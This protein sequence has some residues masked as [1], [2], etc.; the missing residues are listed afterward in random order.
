MLP[1]PRL[2]PSQTDKMLL[3]LFYFGAHDD[4]ILAFN[5]LL[6]HPYL[7]LISETP[8]RLFERALLFFFDFILMYIYERGILDAYI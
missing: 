7:P 2:R 3:F 5:F 6:L 4:C 1:A 8:S